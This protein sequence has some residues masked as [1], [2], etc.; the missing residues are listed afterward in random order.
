[1]KFIYVFLT[2]FL[3]V[4]PVNAKTTFPSQ[5]TC[6]FQVFRTDVPDVKENYTIQIVSGSITENSDRVE[7][8]YNGD[9][10]TV[11]CNGNTIGLNGTDIMMCRIDRTGNVMPDTSISGG[12]TAY[13]PYTYS[14]THPHEP[15]LDYPTL[16]GTTELNPFCEAD[17]HGRECK[18]QVQNLDDPDLNRY[19]VGINEWV[20]YAKTEVGFT[21]GYTVDDSILKPGD[22]VCGED[23]IGDGKVTDD[24]EYT[25][26]M[27]GNP[28]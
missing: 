20:V 19:G 7:I 26:C 3:V 15:A 5:S 21:I 24:T 25:F 27:P 8:I 1:M 2:L 16:T 12:I 23:L 22:V 28:N 11:W 17:E 10:K 9:R 4:P 6:Q 14:N 18:W 13:S